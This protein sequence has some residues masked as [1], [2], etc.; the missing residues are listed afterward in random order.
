LVEDMAIGMV[1]GRRRIEEG[2]AKIKDGRGKGENYTSRGWKPGFAFVC[3]VT[4]RDRTRAGSL[5][6][7]MTLSVESGLRPALSP[8]TPTH[9]RKVF[10]ALAVVMCVDVMSGV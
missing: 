1:V 6:L 3:K 7:T 9:K 4:W 8:R 2:E 10:R 5:L